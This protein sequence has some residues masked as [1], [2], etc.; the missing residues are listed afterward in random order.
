V[1][2]AQSDGAGAALGEQAWQDGK[3][4]RGDHPTV[5]EA[6]RVAAG[7]DRAS[8]GDIDFG[9]VQSTQQGAGFVKLVNNVP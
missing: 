7:G 4:Q 8:G 6:S 5:G 2:E 9:G 1:P 3:S